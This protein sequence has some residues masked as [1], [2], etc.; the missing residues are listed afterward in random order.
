LVF[1]AYGTSPNKYSK[2]PLLGS[3]DSL[4][5]AIEEIVVLKSNGRPI[6]VY[7]T[8]D[9]NYDQIGLGEMQLKRG[10]PGRWVKAQVHIDTGSGPKIGLVT[11]ENSYQPKETSETS[12]TS[13]LTYV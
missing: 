5:E 8:N 7:G 6:F 9:L 3:F 12:E 11:E 1:N 13:E 2:A 4:E 10:L